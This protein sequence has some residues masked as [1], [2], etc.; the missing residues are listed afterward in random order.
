[1]VKIFSHIEEASQLDPPGRTPDNSIVPGVAGSGV[2]LELPVLGNW[3]A[4]I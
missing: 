3:D 4:R 2:Q 1:M